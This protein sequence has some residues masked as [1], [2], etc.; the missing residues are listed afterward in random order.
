MENTKN[1]ITLRTRSTPQEESDGWDAYDSLDN[2]TEIAE[3]SEAISDLMK[4][5]E[6]IPPDQLDMWSHP[7]VQGF[8]SFVEMKIKEMQ[9]YARL[10]KELEIL[11]FSEVNL[12]LANHYEVFLSLLSLYNVAIMD[13]EREAMNYQEWFDE[14]YLKIR[15]RENTVGLSAN[16]WLS[17]KEIESMVRV[18]N[19]EDYQKK[20]IATIASERQVAFLLRL[21]DSWE[22]QKYAL[23]TISKNMQIEYRNSHMSDSSQWD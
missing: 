22:S 17:Q 11:T 7:K 6:D 15:R 21:R 19:K 20:K 14:Q 9:E 5:A 18:E 16:K 10:S 23:Q 2:S 12:K 3:H 8:L 13:K 4:E 1:K